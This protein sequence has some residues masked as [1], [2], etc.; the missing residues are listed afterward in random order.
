[1][2]G[3]AQEPARAGQPAGR[4]EDPVPRSDFKRVTEPQARKQR[5]RNERREQD[6][7]IGAEPG[8]RA[9]GAPR[10]NE[11]ARADQYDELGRRPVGGRRVGEER[12]P[13]RRAPRP[14]REGGGAFERRGPSEGDGIV[15]RDREAH[16]V[17]RNRGPR[18]EEERDGQRG[19]QGAAPAVRV[20]RELRRELPGQREPGVV[21][22]EEREARGRHEPPLGPAR[23]VV[24]HE[25]APGEP[26]GGQSAEQHGER[27]GASLGGMYS[28]WGVRAPSSA[29]FHD[30]PP[31]RSRREIAA[32]TGSVVTTQSREK[33]GA[34]ATESL[35]R[36]Q[37]K[38]SRK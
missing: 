30:R 29:R 38:R 22:R 34:Q 33:S 14:R 10:R 23:I 21:V 6:R 4:R 26:V 18:Q 17:G 11:Q 13:G 36:R 7:G 25:P 5:G 37:K 8:R 24:G 35:T 12:P 27:V 31:I 9:A 1:M 19:T 32:R 3:P 20:E 2:A 28:R 15:V 16:L